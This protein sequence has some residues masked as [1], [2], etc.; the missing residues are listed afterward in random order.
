MEPPGEEATGAT[1]LAVQEGFTMS[2][3]RDTKASKPQEGAARRFGGIAFAGALLVGMATSAADARVVQREE[4]WDGHFA[5]AFG[6]R[7]LGPDWGSARRQYMMG[8]ESDV[9]P[10]AWP[11][12]LVLDASAGAEN[13]DDVDATF[14][15]MDLGLRRVFT[16]NR[17]VWPE[18]G[19]G[20]R[21]GY[22]SASLEVDGQDVSAS[23]WGVGWWLGGGVLFP[24]DR[25]LYF[26]I[27]GRYAA[28]EVALDGIG[29][30]P[31]TN[32]GGVYVS[33]VVGSRW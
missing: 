30:G 1:A 4:R 12:S 21:L 11:I 18:V 32:I 20:L 26:G 5:L 19:G 8:F 15:Q 28:V 22:A 16:P 31:T 3:S 2:L 27:T 6:L 17:W 13:T 29:G 23:G 7:D 33:A 24:I 10:V 9:R 14:V 25:K